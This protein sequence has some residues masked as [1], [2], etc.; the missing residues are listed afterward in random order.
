MACIRHYTLLFLGLLFLSGRTVSAF[1]ATLGGSCTASGPE[2]ESQCCYL[3]ICSHW[4]NCFAEPPTSNGKALGSTCSAS[5][6][7]CASGCCYLATCSDHSVCFGSSDSPP[8]S[9]SSSS[10]SGG[11]GSENAPGYINLEYPEGSSCDVTKHDDCA[12]HC[13]FEGVCSSPAYCGSMVPGPAGASF[14]ASCSA[15]MDCASECCS[16]GYCSHHANCFGTS[17]D[18]TKIPQEYLDPSYQ[19]LS[20]RVL[21]AQDWCL[22][23]PTNWQI[24]GDHEFE[25]NILCSPSMVAASG[26]RLPAAPDGIIPQAW[27]GTGHDGNGNTWVQMSGRLNKGYFAEGDTGGQVGFSPEDY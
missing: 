1:P 7:E 16:N 26:G 23:F 19:P 10:S 27:Y 6:P 21:S 2:C 20:L 15:N 5:G 17:T 3:G 8:A 12:S 24:I 9:S 4:S 18:L 14:G 22:M 11:Q 25:A 13:C